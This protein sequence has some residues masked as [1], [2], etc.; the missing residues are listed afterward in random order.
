[1]H[2][3]RTLGM[4]LLVVTL[5]PAIARADGFIVPFAGVNFGGNAGKEDFGDAADAERFNFGVSLGWMGGGVFGFEADFA[6]SPDFYGETDLGGSGVT[7][8]MGNLLVG[9]PFGGQQG[10]GIRPF[11]LVGIGVLRSDL[12]GFDDVIGF[13]NNE[14]AWNFGGGLMFFFSSHVGIRGD[15]RYFR[16]FDAIDFGFINIAEEE[17]IDFARGAVGLVI[18]F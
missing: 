10:F 16:T 8:F 3:W 11:G 12:E 9:V 13:D 14:V 5:S 15:V 4:G 7:S 17:N 1:M 2:L 6:Y 18:R